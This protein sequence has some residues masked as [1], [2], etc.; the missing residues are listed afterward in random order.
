MILLLGLIVCFGLFVTSLA[1]GE[2]GEGD[3]EG[4]WRGW[5]TALCA[6]SVIAGAMFSI[7]CL[8]QPIATYGNNAEIL[9]LRQNI[10]IAKAAAE[11][12]N[13]VAMV[14]GVPDGKMIG[15]LEN[16]QQ[17]QQ[18]S[19]AWLTYRDMQMRL[20]A[21]IA[22]RKVWLASPLTNW[23]TAPLPTE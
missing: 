16:M 22:S 14:K 19:A 20:N 12:L 23:L 7:F 1:L 4:S 10:P 18:T 13:D 11:A 5:R 15:G 3:Y 17:S 21:L 9:A 8:G 6:C 2:I